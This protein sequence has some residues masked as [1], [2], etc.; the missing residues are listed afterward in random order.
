MAIEMGVLEG[1]QN[2]ALSRPTPKASATAGNPK[3]S[4]YEI[5]RT[6]DNSVEI[7]VWECTPG[8]F[9]ATR[10][11]YDE[12]CY[13]MSGSAKITQDVGPSVVLSA[14][15]TLV[16]PEGWTGEWEVLETLRKIYVIQRS[17]Q[18]PDSAGQEAS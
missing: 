13:V 2:L 12:V 14:G 3:E 17:P 1:V 4:A 8:S 11:G 9:L 10:E 5:W 16:T 7:G 18:R 15:D 6:S